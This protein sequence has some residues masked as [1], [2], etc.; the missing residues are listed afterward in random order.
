M[1]KISQ[2]FLES[3]KAAGLTQIKFAVRSRR[4]ICILR[5]IE[6]GIR[7]DHVSTVNKA[8]AKKGMEVIPG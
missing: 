3:R 5:G 6:L 4:E 2:F 7:T 8:M 1:N